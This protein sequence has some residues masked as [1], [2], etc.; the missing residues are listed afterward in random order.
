MSAEPLIQIAFLAD[1]PE[2]LPTIAG[3]VYDEWEQFRPGAAL[4]ETEARFRTHLQRDA[5]PLTLIALRGS[6]LV[7][8]ASIFVTDMTT[9]LEL[10]PWLAA[11][12]VAAE[13]RG[14]GIGSQLV[15][16]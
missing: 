6:T 15:A 16:A 12:Y 14:N 11:V 10:G 3:W 13:Q 9:H 1:Y 5:I 7:G 2:H 8:T 4:Q